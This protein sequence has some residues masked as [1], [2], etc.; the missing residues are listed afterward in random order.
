MSTPA[1]LDD[2]PLPEGSLGE[3][4]RQEVEEFIE[5]GE[6]HFNRYKGWLIKKSSLLERAMLVMA[7]ALVIVPVGAR[8]IDAAA[9][10]IEM[11]RKSPVAA[12]P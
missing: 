4:L 8:K 5:D 12:S 7:G 2:N 6:G 3:N 9:L 10:V 1:S 11:P